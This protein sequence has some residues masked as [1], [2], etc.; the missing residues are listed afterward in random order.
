MSQSFSK[1]PPTL[2]GDVIACSIYH[3]AYNIQQQSQHVKQKKRENL[4]QRHGLFFCFPCRPAAVPAGARTG[5]AHFASR[6]D[7]LW[8][9][10]LSLWR[11]L[12]D[13]IQHISDSIHQ[14]A[15]SIQHTEQIIYHT[16]D[17][18]QHIASSIQHIASS[19]QQ[20][21]DSIQHIPHSRQQVA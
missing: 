5:G 6:F 21:A 7:F 12:A 8:C 17:S 18:I 1:R 13:R 11:P 2:H 19:I 14:L 10:A 9:A 20:I 3:I 15:Y 4:R 16:A